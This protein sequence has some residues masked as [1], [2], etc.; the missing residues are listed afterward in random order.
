M[1]FDHA[2]ADVA[3]YLVEKLH[4]LDEPDYLPDAHLAT[5]THVGLRA[6]GR[7]AVVEAGERCRDHV[8]AEDRPRFDGRCFCWRWLTDAGLTRRLGCA[9]LRCPR[10]ECRGLLQDERRLAGLDLDLGKLRFVQQR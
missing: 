2:T 8:A 5:L 4:C 7:R 1:D 9:I 10:H 3:L 6:R